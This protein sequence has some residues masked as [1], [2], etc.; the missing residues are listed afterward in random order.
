MAEAARWP[1][2]ERV[3]AAQCGTKDRLGMG[4][5]GEGQARASCG[6]TGV[7]VGQGQ[8]PANVCVRMPAWWRRGAVRASV[9]GCA[10]ACR[11]MRSCLWYVCECGDG[12][13]VARGASDEACVQTWACL[14]I[15]LDAARHTADTCSARSLSV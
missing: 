11:H 12:E 5:E 14:V 6:E 10:G 13:L 2:Q 4:I 7:G 9:R 3:R 15:Q 1:T 8:C